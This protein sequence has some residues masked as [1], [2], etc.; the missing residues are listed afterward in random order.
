[1]RIPTLLWLESRVGERGQAACQKLARKG[2]NRRFAPKRAGAWAA[3]TRSGLLPACKKWGSR[4]ASDSLTLTSIT[5]LWALPR[6]MR[7]RRS[8]WRLKS[9]QPRGVRI[10]DCSGLPCEAAYLGKEIGTRRAILP[11]VVCRSRRTPHIALSGAFLALS[12]PECNRWPR[13]CTS[14]QRR[15]WEPGRICHIPA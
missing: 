6:R 14:G 11:V 1:M 8:A 2:A 13:G 9:S 10:P 12:A 4:R 3:L 7:R 15:E 5:T